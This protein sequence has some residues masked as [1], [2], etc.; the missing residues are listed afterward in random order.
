MQRTHRATNGACD[1]GAKLSVKCVDNVGVIS[2]LVFL[3]CLIGNNLV[4]NIHQYNPQISLQN[5][6]RNL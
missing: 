2:L 5:H 4:I 6:F 3:P 1:F